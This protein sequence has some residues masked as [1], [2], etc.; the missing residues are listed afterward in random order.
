MATKL[1]T[2]G[3]K[4]LLVG[5]LVEKH[6]YCGFPYTTPHF[7]IIRISVSVVLI[8]DGISGRATKK[9]LYLFCCFPYLQNGR[10]HDEQADVKICYRQVYKKPKLNIPGSRA[11]LRMRADPG[12]LV[13]SGPDFFLQIHVFHLEYRVYSSEYKHIC[14]LICSYLFD[15]QFLSLGWVRIEIK[16][17]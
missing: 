10:N 6:F 11:E 5:P 3:I 7:L 12:Y 8:L 15:L 4:A 13:G 17:I 2:G 1:K 16:T 14:T 9:E